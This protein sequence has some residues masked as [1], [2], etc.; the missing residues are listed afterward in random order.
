MEGCPHCVEQHRKFV[1][2]AGGPSSLVC[3][4]VDEAILSK[5]MEKEYLGS[6]PAYPY[7]YD[8][9]G[10]GKRKKLGNSMS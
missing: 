8:V 7:F 10:P 5:E 4:H 3:Y 6:N 9:T 1:R 2:Y